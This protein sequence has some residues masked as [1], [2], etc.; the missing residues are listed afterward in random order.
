[1]AVKRKY[2][3]VTAYVGMPGSGKSYGLAEEGK[4]ALDRGR[5][6]FSNA[7]F[8]FG[9]TATGWRDG[10]FQFGSFEELVHVP[11]GATI[12]IDEAPLYF[13]ARKWQDFPDGFMYRLTQV[14]KDGLEVYYST[15]DWRMVDV[16]LR[17][18]TFWV[19][20]CKALTGRL[21][22]RRMFPPEERRKKDERARRSEFVRV[23]P[24][25]SE[26]YD[27]LGKVSVRAGALNASSET[28]AQ[29]GSP[30]VASTAETAE[31]RGRPAGLPQVE[32]LPNVP[33]VEVPTATIPQRKGWSG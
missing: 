21:L 15:I 28:W 11:Q 32:P 9:A 27:T 29:I 30:P 18:M 33:E 10:C 13:N 22:H 8:D 20:E 24:S 1:M 2:Q 4:R 3:G 6:V 19:W 5:P 23:K 14:R 16:Q 25:V 17:R 26:L 7:G 31:G 12:L